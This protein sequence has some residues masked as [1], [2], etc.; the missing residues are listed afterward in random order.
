MYQI[1]YCIYCYVSTIF[2]YKQNQ[3]F[4]NIIKYFGQNISSQNFSLNFCFVFGFRI[5]GKPFS[6]L[7]YK[8]KLWDRTVQLM[9]TVSC[10]LCTVH[11]VLVLYTAYLYCALCT[12]Y[13][14][15]RICTVHSLL[16][17]VHC[18]LCTVYCVLYTAY[19]YCALFTVYFAL[20][21][22][23]CTLHTVFCSL[24]NGRLWIQMSVHFVKLSCWEILWK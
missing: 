14:I 12:V 20:C 11:C 13:R 9:C 1:A 5:V 22:V 4:L 16:F 17:T 8:Y 18:V 3:Q 10:V 7:L 21:T 19:L 2:F 15:L 6:F 23:Y 24:C